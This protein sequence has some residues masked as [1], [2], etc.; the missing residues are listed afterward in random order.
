MRSKL[1]KE[2]IEIV[3]GFIFLIAAWLTVLLIAT[4]IIDLETDFIIIV[5]LLCY[6]LSV[7]GLVLSSHGLVT[8][9]IARRFKKKPTLT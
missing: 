4:G 6:A 3:I 2:I 1:D 5:T 8:L 9:I 7:A